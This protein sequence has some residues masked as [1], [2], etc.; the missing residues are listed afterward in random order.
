MKKW[1]KWTL[2]GLTLLAVTYYLAWLEFDRAFTALIV[3][4]DASSL[5]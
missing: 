4:A 1:K 2:C 5:H 3:A